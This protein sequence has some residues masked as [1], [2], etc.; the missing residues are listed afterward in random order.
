[1]LTIVA[2]IYAE[3][4]HSE[5]VAAELQKLV[6]I[7]RAEAGCRQY[8]LHRDNDNPDHF[9]FYENWDSR[10]LWQTH[11]AAPHLANYMA[12]TEGK[13]ARFDLFEMTLV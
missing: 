10:D 2:H 4:G 1:M 3:P 8:D 5:F 13:V 6:P 12:A 9:M 11:M 7:T